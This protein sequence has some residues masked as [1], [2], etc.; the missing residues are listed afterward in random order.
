M[1][2]CVRGGFKLQQ[3]IIKVYAEKHQNVVR[4]VMDHLQ[5]C[6]NPGLEHGRPRTEPP[7]EGA[8]PNGGHACGHTEAGTSRK[9]SKTRLSAGSR[10]LRVRQ[11]GSGPG[12]D[13]SHSHPQLSI[14]RV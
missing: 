8:G 7:R 3:P 1:Q 9:N 13:H 6:R 14:A 4:S 12:Q 5:W 11:L 10:C 2:L